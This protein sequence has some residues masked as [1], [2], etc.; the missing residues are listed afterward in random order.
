MRMACKKIGLVLLAAVFC[1]GPSLAQEKLRITPELVAA[2]EAEGQFTLQYTSP[3]NS[4]QALISEFSRK[5][6]KV[7]VNLERKA[8]TR[9]AQIMQQEFDAGVNRIDIFQGSDIDSNAELVEHKLFAAID[10]ETPNPLPQT[11]LTLAPY[12]YFPDLTRPVFMYNPTQVTQAEADKLRDWKGILD[13]V[14]KNRVSLVEPIFGT[15]LSPLLYIMNTPGMGEDFLRKLKQQNPV[16]FLNTAQA[17]EAMISGQTPISWGAQFESI[18]LSEIHRGAPVRF[19][20]PTPTVEY[21][22]NAWGVLAKA[23]HPKAARLF[24]AWLMS[25]DGGLAIESPGY[26]G[27]S[28]LVGPEDTRAMV[29]ELAGKPW[30]HAPEKAWSPDMKDWIANGAKYRETWNSI[31]KRRN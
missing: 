25:R 3:L 6:P 29:K 24:F 17:R 21:G 22:G 5:Y 23:P 10:P 9:G 26:N 27:R 2:A 16:I 30:Y 13:P 19:V 4:M 20:Y 8:G 7:R 14:F 12:L 18:A 11:A 31:L 1:S 28:V 15:T